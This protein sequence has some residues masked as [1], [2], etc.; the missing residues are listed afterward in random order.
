[1]WNYDKNNP[2]NATC[3]ESALFLDPPTTFIGSINY[4]YPQG[5]E[6]N[7]KELEKYIGKDLMQ[8][9]NFSAKKGVFKDI[10]HQGNISNTKKINSSRIQYA[11]PDG[12]WVCSA[13]QNYNFRG[14]L[15]CNRCSKIRDGNDFSGKP[16]HLMK[17]DKI[18]QVKQTAIKIR[19]GD[20]N[21]PF[22][23]NINFAYRSTGNKCKK[24]K[25][26]FLSKNI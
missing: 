14:R 25:E 12:G 3:F 2:N 10:S 8:E 19:Q 7:Q 17:Y 24:S 20:W 4:F 16:S 23:D 11:F 13:C 5:S 22:C 21:C 15:Q 1:M 9:I 18:L 6:I 26:E